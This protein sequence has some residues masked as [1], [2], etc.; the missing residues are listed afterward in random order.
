MYFSLVL[1]IWSLHILIARNCCSFLVDTDLYFQFSGRS[2]AVHDSLRGSN[3]ILITYC[4]I[5]QFRSK[6]SLQPDLLTTV[7][8]NLVREIS[9]INQKCL[10]PLV[11]GH[12]LAMVSRID[13]IHR[14]WLKCRYM[15][16]VATDAQVMAPVLEREL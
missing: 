8:C 13:L 5:N 10:S 6:A 1:Y 3:V 15:D 11:T 4:K 14:G 12:E 9:I 2:G 16:R 7:L